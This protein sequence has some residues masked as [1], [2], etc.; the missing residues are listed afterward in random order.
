MRE[1]PVF[2]NLFKIK[3]PLAGFISITHRISGIVFFLGFPLLIYV[4]K[5]LPIK[6]DLLAFLGNIWVRF[7]I[8]A[9]VSLYVYHFFA[10]IRHMVA[11]FGHDHS[12][13]A[14]NRSAIIVLVLGIVF[15]L[16][17]GVVL[18]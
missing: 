6:A 9:L 10:G 8:W 5:I 7:G 16:Y 13:E 14:A 11:D 4:Y 17:L 2:L 12:L 1:R 18:W 3:L 15:A